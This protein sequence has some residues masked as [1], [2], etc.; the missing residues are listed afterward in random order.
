MNSWRADFGPI[1][2][3]KNPKNKKGWEKMVEKVITG[4][5]TGVDQTAIIT[6]ASYGLKTGGIMPEGWATNDGPNP[7]F[8]QRYGLREGTSKDPAVRTEANVRNSD[9]T[10]QLALNFKSPGMKCTNKFIL[11]HKKPTYIID[12]N[13]FE[14]IEQDK[15]NIL[16]NYFK[17]WITKEKIKTLNIAGNRETKN[18]KI[19]KKAKPVLEALFEG[20]GLNKIPGQE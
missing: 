14:C 9:G 20:L 17:C 2:A 10:L 1:L 16:L 3:R 8:G 7:Y 19:S 13:V 4:G 6:A 15:K 5:Q 18:N 12:I 11:K